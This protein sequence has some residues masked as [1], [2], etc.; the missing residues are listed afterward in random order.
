MAGKKRRSTVVAKAGDRL[1]DRVLC[2]D[3]VSLHC[4][5]TRGILWASIP[6]SSIVSPALLPSVTRLEFR[7]DKQAP[8]VPGVELTEIVL[9]QEHA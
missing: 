2:T 4:H 9:R 7:G 5:R 1:V 3:R 8:G 6:S